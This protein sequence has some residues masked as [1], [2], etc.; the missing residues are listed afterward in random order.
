M[1]GA[2]AVVVAAGVVATRWL[3]GR[4]SVRLDPDVAALFEGLTPGTRLDRWTLEAVHPVTLGAVPVVMATQDGRR[5]Q[6]DVLARDP[7]GPASVAST[8]HLSL[9]VQNQGDGSTR[10]DEEQGLGAMVLADAL[11]QREN[12]GAPIPELLTLDERHRRHP[13]GSFGVPIS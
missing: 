1:A 9:F 10:T 12:A 2:G 6:V 4:S 8:A 3:G 13:D 5:F 11:R 7:Q